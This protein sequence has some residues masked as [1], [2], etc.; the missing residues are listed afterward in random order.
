MKLVSCGSGYLSQ[1]NT[2][3]HFGIGN[4]AE[5]SEITIIWPGKSIQK[6][7]TPQKANQTLTIIEKQ[8]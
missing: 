4:A 1:E 5:V 7:K 6:I 2:T 3:L 8:S